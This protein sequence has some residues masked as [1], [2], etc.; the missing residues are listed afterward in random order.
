MTAAYAPE[1]LH[2]M[3]S[4]RALAL[5]CGVLLHA[6][7]SFLPGVAGWPAADVRPS[8]SM[9]WITF[10]IHVF[11]MT[12]F[13]LIAGF[14]AR[15]LLHRRGLKGFLGN[16][17]TRIAVPL[18]VGWPILLAGIVAAFAWGGLVMHGDPNARIPWIVRAPLA[19]RPLGAAPLAH[20]WFLYFLLVYYALALALRGC[21]VLADPG[22]GLRQRIDVLVRALMHTPL[23]PIALGAPL[24][25]AFY[26]APRWLM[27]S[28][29]PT[30]DKS[31]IPDVTALIGYGTAFGFGWLLHR[32]ADLLAAMERRWRLNLALTAGL[33]LAFLALAGPL[34]SHM[35]EPTGPAKAVGAAIYATVVWTSTFAVV[36]MAYRFLSG[37]SPLRRY[38]AD[39]SYW[40]Y[41]VHLPLVMALQVAVSQLGWPAWVKLAVILGVAVPVM[42]LSYEFLVRYTVIGAV[43]NGPRRRA[44]R[45]HARAALSTAAN[46]V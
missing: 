11:R 9:A 24:A 39:A 33:A 5:L 2:A 3:D 15:M 40:I 43:L 7:M 20:L 32:Q 38:F 6:M 46:R 1:R 25:V 4:V 23:A 45:G 17:L 34:P 35:P 41:L 36:G 10:V 13:F 18:A 26:L 14:F 27:W 44:R 16:R 8:P 21:V 30:P 12:T 31:L 37:H 28:G 19:A 42:L 29:M 22:G